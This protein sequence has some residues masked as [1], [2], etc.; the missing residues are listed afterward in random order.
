M[1][2]DFFP[3]VRQVTFGPDDE[4]QSID[5]PLLEKVPTTFRCVAHPVPT[6]RFSLQSRQNHPMVLGW[7]IPACAN[8]RMDSRAHFLECTNVPTACRA[9]FLAFWNVMRLSLCG[10]FGI[11]K[12][13]AGPPRALS[14]APQSRHGRG[15][16]PFRRAKITPRMSVRRF[17]DAQTRKRDP[18]R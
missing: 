1:A 18:V 7:S 13:L 10:D 17:W 12:C 14:G 3:Q 15:Q 5:C 6:R 9:Y 11:P 4:T 2:V 8:L 16:V